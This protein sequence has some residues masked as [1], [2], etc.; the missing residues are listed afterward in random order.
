MGDEEKAK[1][2]R[3]VYRLSRRIGP[4]QRISGLAE[5]TGAANPSVAVFSSGL[6]QYPQTPHPMRFLKA[7]AE[8]LGEP[9][10][11]V[12]P[13]AAKGAGMVGAG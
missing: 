12:T 8:I 10:A 9:P 5:R 3:A 13:G 7:M 1:A 2:L 6:V 11:G 4:V